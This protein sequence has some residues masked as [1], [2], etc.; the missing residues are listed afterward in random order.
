MSHDITTEQQ[1]PESWIKRLNN[2]IANKTA[3]VLSS[4]WLFWILV[5]AIIAA[6]V[7]QPPKGAFDISL[8]FIST[9]FQGIALP[10]LA[11]VSNIQGDKQ[12]E[13]LDNMQS[14][15][16]KELKL[17]KELIKDVQDE[18]KKIE[19]VAHLDTDAPAIEGSDS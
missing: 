5:V 11:F 8:F 15:I 13:Q 18:Q 17:I 14:E 10:V 1:P 12:Q 3:V 4:M 7:M 6:Y 2:A 16:H 19:S 9:A